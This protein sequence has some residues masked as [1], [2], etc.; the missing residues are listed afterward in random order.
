MTA[1]PT[2]SPHEAP[3]KPPDPGTAHGRHHWWRWV[4]GVV[5]VLL[6]LFVARV[7]GR[8]APGGGAVPAAMMA[9]V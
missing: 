2:T 7:V 6:V 4:G 5:A 8:Q 9:T 3:N 1:M